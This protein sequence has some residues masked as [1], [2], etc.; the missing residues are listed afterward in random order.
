MT[1]LVLFFCD[2]HICQPSVSFFNDYCIT[3]VCRLSSSF[4]RAF[5]CFSTA[6]CELVV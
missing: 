6:V 3:F 1:S 2:V 4:V 5:R